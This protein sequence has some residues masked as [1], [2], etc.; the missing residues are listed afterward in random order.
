MGFEASHCN[1]TF[2]PWAIFC[3]T[4]TRRIANQALRDI[5]YLWGKIY[6]AE[7]QPNISITWEYGNRFHLRI[8]NIHLDLFSFW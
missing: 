5:F 6:M 4:I 3:D 7:Y 1:Q 2:T 8:F